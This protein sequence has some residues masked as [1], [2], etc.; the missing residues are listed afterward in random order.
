MLLRHLVLTTFILCSTAAR[1]DAQQFAPERPRRLLP[2]TPRQLMPATSSEAPVPTETAPTLAPEI[3]QS[4]NNQADPSEKQNP[5]NESF[6]VMPDGIPALNI[7]PAVDRPPIPPPPATAALRPTGSG[8]VSPPQA[9]RIKAFQLFKQKPD[10]NIIITTFSAPYEN[11]MNS[12]RQALSDE[13]LTVAGFS[14]TSGHMLVTFAD[15]NAGVSARAE[16]AI[17]AMRPA[18]PAAGEFS[19]NVTASNGTSNNATEVRISCENRNRNLT[20]SRM[21]EI[22]TRLESNFGMARKDANQL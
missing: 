6:S 20:A 10:A 19:S 2:A 12:M 13:G 7:V 16:K 15:I 4:N 9:W 22:A 21:K 11:A 17:I 18:M 5:E 1:A 14:Q 3:R 8:Q